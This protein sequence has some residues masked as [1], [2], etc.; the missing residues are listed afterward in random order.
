MENTLQIE[1]PNHNGIIAGDDMGMDYWSKEFG[2]SK[3]ELMATVKA[4]GT[5]TEALEKYIKEI[6]F[7]A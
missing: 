1:L 6:N 2:I 5:S 3:D 4:G 7:S